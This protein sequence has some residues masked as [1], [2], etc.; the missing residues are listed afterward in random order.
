M[1]SISKKPLT[2]IEPYVNY[3]EFDLFLEYIGFLVKKRFKTGY[4]L[5]EAE[6]MGWQRRSAHKAFVCYTDGSDVHVA[7]QF[8]SNFMPNCDWSATVYSLNGG[9][10]LYINVKH[11]DNPV[12]GDHFY[13]LPISQRRYE[14]M[15]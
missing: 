7:N 11:H 13:L 12:N 6:N 3:T 14:Q 4:V 8:F 9:K 15:K 5:C 1:K 10:G 2:S